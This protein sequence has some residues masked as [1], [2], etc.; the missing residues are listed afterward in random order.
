MT[1]KDETIKGLHDCKQ[2]LKLEVSQLQVVAMK[3]DDVELTNSP[4]Y[5]PTFDA[6]THI[7]VDYKMDDVE[8]FTPSNALLARNTM[9]SPSFEKYS[10][11]IGS[12]YP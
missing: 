7:H 12:C 2:G 4:I 8:V 3:F 11:C 1:E 5:S 9:I 6:P 10:T